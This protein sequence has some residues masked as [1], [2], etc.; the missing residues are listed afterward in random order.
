MTG[1]QHEPWWALEAAVRAGD[2]VGLQIHLGSLLPGE[3][4]RAISR[5]DRGD[6]ERLL[7]LLTPRRAA[8]LLGELP[9]AQA[10]ALFGGLPPAAAAAVLAQ[11]PGADRAD[12]LAGIDEAAAEAVL[13][14]SAPEVVESARTLSRYPAD[15][16]GGLMTAEF[17]AYP[18]DAHSAD[19]VD[20]LRRRAAEYSRYRVQYAYVTS[21][22]GAPVGVLRLRDLLLAPAD[23][24]LADVMTPDPVGVSVGTPLDELRRLFDRYP[25]FGLPVTGEDGRLL[26]VVLRADVGEA[27]GERAE[28][29][30][31]VASGV[32]GGEELRSMPLAGRLARRLAWL[33]VSAGLNL[34]SASVVGLYQET[35]AAAITL[36]VFLPVISGMGGNSGNQSLAV[37][38]RE[39]SLGLVRPGDLSW[40]LAREIGIGV[41]CGAALG[42]LL[43]GVALAWT[44]STPVAL[45]VGAAMALSTVAAVCL[46]GVLPL[47]LQR[48]GVD[49]A[50]ASGPIL[51]TAT[52][53]CAFFLALSF[54]AAL[55]P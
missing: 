25:F 1:R 54:A 30:F 28:R 34:L 32:L 15:T 50:L 10:A 8:D 45:A 29:T 31:L 6:Q 19:V 18:L 26:G 22:D 39:M 7:A 20:D 4:G 3:V 17:L 40:V 55:L 37:S 36:A 49:P 13:A 27:V 52:D 11:V 38:I 43:G 33:A 12:L 47:A 24:R 2:A 46:G 51:T 23:A 42:L 44:G 48:L 14:C 41:A 53:A 21:G 16:A 9:H 5:L 35:L